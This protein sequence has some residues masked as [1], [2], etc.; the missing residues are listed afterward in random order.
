MTISPDNMYQWLETYGFPFKDYI[1]DTTVYLGDAVR[2]GKNLMFE[3]QLGALRGYR[4]RHLPVYVLVLHDRGL[5]ADR[6][7]HSVLQGG[8]RGR[9]YESLSSCVGKDRLPVSFW[10]G[11]R[12]TQRGR[13]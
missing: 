4:L 1:K 9:H 11:G 6:R 8:L 12:Q 7:G 2:A 10:R 13:R 3:A 5:C